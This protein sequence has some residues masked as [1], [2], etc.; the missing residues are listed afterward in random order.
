[1]EK[2]G[3]LENPKSWP[4]FILRVDSHMS[5]FL[6]TGK[7]TRLAILSSALKVWIL[8]K[9]SFKSF[10]QKLCIDEVVSDY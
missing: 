4:R 6:T 1:M 9:V 3:D 5:S 7:R 8:L 10:S 2:R